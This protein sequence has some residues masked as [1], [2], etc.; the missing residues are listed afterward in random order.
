[1][2][3]EQGRP[4]MQRVSTRKEVSHLGYVLEEERFCLQWFGQ[5][6]LHSYRRTLIRH[7]SGCDCGVSQS[8]LPWRTANRR[9]IIEST[10]QGFCSLK[11]KQRERASSLLLK[12]SIVLDRVYLLLLL[13]P[14]D[15]RFFSQSSNAVP[16]QW[17]SRNLENLPCC[18]EHH[19]C[20]LMF[21]G[22]HLLKLSSYKVL[23]LLSVQLPTMDYPTSATYF[24]FYDIYIFLF[25]LL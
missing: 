24:L 20:Y 2:R 10:F 3:V 13:S 19:S 12:C 15:I 14:V 1:M 9:G 4:D 8:W 11:K 21:C 7:N 23:W 6:E 5:A 17:L 16:H 25:W 18:T 22:F